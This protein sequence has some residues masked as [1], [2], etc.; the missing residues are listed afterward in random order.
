V[1]AGRSASSY[2]P[3]VFAEAGGEWKAAQERIAAVARDACMAVCGPNCLGIMNYVDGIPLTL[4]P[5]PPSPL[6]GEGRKGAAPSL[7]IVAQSGRTQ[8]AQSCAA[9]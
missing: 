2:S 9:A 7:S 4:S 8:D 3:P 5:Q 1:R 6:A